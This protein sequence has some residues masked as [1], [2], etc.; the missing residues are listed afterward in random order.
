MKTEKRKQ[1]NAAKKEWKW[2]QVPWL[3]VCAPTV[4]VWGREGGMGRKVEVEVKVEEKKK[5]NLHLWNGAA[6]G[7][8]GEKQ[9]KQQWMTSSCRNEYN[10]AEMQS[11]GWPS[12]V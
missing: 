9:Y 11:H 10:Q 7:K 1:M 2:N 8:A 3:S 4:H 5:K 6:H 12:A